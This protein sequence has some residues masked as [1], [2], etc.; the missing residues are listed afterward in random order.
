MGMTFIIRA[1]TYVLGLC[2]SG[3]NVDFIEVSKEEY[4]A[5]HSWMSCAK[6]AVERPTLVSLILAGQ[7]FLQSAQA[8]WANNV[9]F[10]QA[11]AC[12]SDG[13]DR[14]S[15]WSSET[16]KLGSTSCFS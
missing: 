4:D 13:R 15:S 12:T 2:R 11:F 6:E 3:K 16:F 14:A 10:C 9:S 5:A 7:G 1:A 8:V